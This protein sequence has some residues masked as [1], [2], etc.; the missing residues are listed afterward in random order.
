MWNKH[1]WMYLTQMT[2]QRP[3][4]FVHSH[5]PTQKFLCSMRNYKENCCSTRENNL[6]S[7]HLKAITESQLVFLH[8]TKSS[9]GNI[10]RLV[11]FNISI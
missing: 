9:Q 3:E 5:G 8:E 7:N 2:K 11:L 4:G 10:A 1:L 6:N